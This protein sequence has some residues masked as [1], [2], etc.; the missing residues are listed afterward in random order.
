[1]PAYVGAGDQTQ[2]LVW[3]VLYELAITQA[4][5]SMWEFIYSEKD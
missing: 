3:Q 5:R 4:L 2:T 1:M